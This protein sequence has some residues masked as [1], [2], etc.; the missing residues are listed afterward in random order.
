L[1][2]FV[3]FGKLAI[4]SNGIIVPISGNRFEN[5]I[6]ISDLFVRFPKSVFIFLKRLA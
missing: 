5:E 1:L 4:M 2:G 6:K 3:L